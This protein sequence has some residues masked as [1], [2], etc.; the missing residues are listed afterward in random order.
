ME[1]LFSTLMPSLD[2]ALAADKP[3]EFKKLNQEKDR[4][5]SLLSDELTKKQTNGFKEAA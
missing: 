5:D 1:N 4:I 2:A 3:D